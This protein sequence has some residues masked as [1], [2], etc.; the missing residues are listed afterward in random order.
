M[1]VADLLTLV[2][3]AKLTSARSQL[4]KMQRVTKIV[5]VIDPVD[6]GVFFDIV[7][8]A[9]QVSVYIRETIFFS[10]KLI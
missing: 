4:K 7:S 6:L 10:V 2:E 1:E 3:L 8:P 5:T 9:V